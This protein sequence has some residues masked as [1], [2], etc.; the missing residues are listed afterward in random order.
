[1]GTR[2][3][4]VTMCTAVVGVMSAGLSPLQSQEPPRR[5]LVLGG[6]P[7][8]GVLLPLGSQWA[9]RPDVSL[10]G[11]L[12][13]MG[14]IAPIPARSTTRLGLGVSALRLFAAGA[15]SLRPYLVARLGYLSIAT[16]GAGG[17]PST[18][19]FEAQAAIGGGVHHQASDRFGL[20]V[21]L[22]ADYALQRTSS[23]PDEFRRVATSTRWQLRPIVGVT[24]RR[25]QRG[26]GR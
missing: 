2:A 20:F 4:I 21:E 14:G 25:A 19:A 9:L 1:M 7:S 10:G 12:S 13:Y 18:D 11:N 6:L 22:L 26:A 24:L 17:D 23:G 15:D 3:L 8:L 16:D 5:A